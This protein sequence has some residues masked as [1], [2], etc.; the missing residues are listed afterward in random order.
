MKPNSYSVIQRI[1]VQQVK[2][3]KD[4]ISRTTSPLHKNLSWDRVERK[5]VRELKKKKNSSKMDDFTGLHTAF[6]KSGLENLL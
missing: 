3:Y 5:T 6:F 4:S 2:Y 1:S